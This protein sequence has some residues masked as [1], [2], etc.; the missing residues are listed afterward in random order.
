VLAC[1]GAPIVF[2]AEPHLDGKQG[3]SFARRDA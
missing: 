2:S 3:S 1:S